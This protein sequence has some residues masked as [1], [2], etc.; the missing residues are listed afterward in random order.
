MALQFLSKEWFDQVLALRA[1]VEATLGADGI[2]AEVKLVKL[3]IS[4]PH[5]SGEK[6]FSL[7]D[8][9]AY[10]GHITDA[11]TKLTVEY[12]VARRLI[13]EGDVSAGMQAFMSGQIRVEGD[14]SKLLLLQQ[15]LAAQ[16][17]PEQLAL[18][19]KVVE[20]TTF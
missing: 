5:E 17:T 14:M 8:G 7:K 20:F 16:P 18:R 3:N 13:I 1:E 2:P 11:D 19:A 12:D 4:V 10:M 9:D 15:H 6:H